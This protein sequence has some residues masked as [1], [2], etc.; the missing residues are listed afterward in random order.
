MPHWPNPA[1][2]DA[3]R[4]W[5][6]LS[7]RHV[8]DLAWLLDAPDLLDP[9]A[10]EWGGRIASLPPSSDAWLAALDRDPQPLRAA[11][12]LD[13]FARLGRYAEKLLAFYFRQRGMLFAHGLQVRAGHGGTLGEFDF[14]LYD[15][16]GLAHR[17]F[18]VKL[19]L[20]ESSGH[21]READ[22]F[23]GPN[24]AD[25]LGAKMRKILDRQLQL[26]HRPEARRCLPFPVTS[27]KA[28]IK[29]WLFYRGEDAVR[30]PAAGL[31]ARHCRGFWCTRSEFEKID[32]DCFALLPRLAWL[33]PAQIPCAA[34][35]DRATLL[36]ACDDRFRRDSMPLM[37]ALLE[38]RGAQAVETGRG[39]I[40]P[41][42]W[43][44]RARARIG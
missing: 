38:A 22:Y 24:L 15:G 37:V 30:A 44:A 18:A 10:P 28:L 3:G 17:E 20:L 14:L 41:D 16:A 40:V 11:L 26:A 43:R 27:A 8:R 9:Q 12:A 2:T 32:G 5:E 36:E 34:A 13:P 39:F 42:D 31:S 35:W 7:D 4:R 21:G 25:T 33:A 19:Y 29:G 6:R 1:P 23:V